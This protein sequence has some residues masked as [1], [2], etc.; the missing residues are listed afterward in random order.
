MLKLS[1]E[2][3]FDDLLP[4][5]RISSS[6]YSVICDNL[7]NIIKNKNEISKY[8]IG[9]LFEMSHIINNTANKSMF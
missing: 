2:L 5:E 9:L 4:E 8:V 3:K 6:S 1:Y 7:Y